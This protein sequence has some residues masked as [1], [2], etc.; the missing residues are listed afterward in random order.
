MLPRLSCR[1]QPDEEASACRACGVRFSLVTRRHHCRRDGKVYCGACTSKRVPLASYV[2]GSSPSSRPGSA[3]VAAPAGSSSGNLDTDVATQG[4]DKKRVCGPCYYAALVEA[5]FE[6]HHAERLR[7]GGRFTLHA[8]A[9]AATAATAAESASERT[10]TREGAPRSSQ[11][12]AH[13]ISL[14]LSEVRGANQ[15]IN[16]PIIQPTDQSW[17]RTVHGCSGGFL[18]QARRHHRVNSCT[19]VRW[20]GALALSFSVAFDWWID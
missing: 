3:V 2:S 8:A 4:A 17:H 9:T 18:D 6:R 13:L 19:G 10:A 20:Y 7:L 16:Q 15:S 12:V 14:F 11:V 1:W 5:E